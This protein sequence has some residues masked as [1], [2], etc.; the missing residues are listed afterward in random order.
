MTCKRLQEEETD[1][2]DD[3][4]LTVLVPRIENHTVHPS[5]LSFQ[6]Q[7]IAFPTTGVRRS[8]HY[9]PKAAFVGIQ[10][11]KY[12][13]WL[14]SDTAIWGEHLNVNPRQHLTSFG[15][16]FGKLGKYHQMLP[17]DLIEKLKDDKGCEEL[18]SPYWL[19]GFMMTIDM[20]VQ[21]GRTLKAATAYNYVQALATFLKWKVR[22]LGKKKVGES[23]GICVW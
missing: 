22:A 20:A 18:F 5:L 9:A 1:S 21:E 6:N 11:G 7:I 4:P 10:L 23:I 3:L 14:S 2:E 19:D 8:A 13:R 16:C 12:V 15:R 17:A